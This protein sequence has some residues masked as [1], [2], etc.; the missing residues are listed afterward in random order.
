[1]ELEHVLQGGIIH[2]SR[3]I[4]SILEEGHLYVEQARKSQR[5]PLISVLMHGPPGSGKTALAA[6]IAKNSEFPFAKLISPENMIQ[7]SERSKVNYLSK[8]FEDAYKSP[9]SVVIVDN[10]ER[11]L[12]FAPIG[13]QFSNA[14]L[15]TLLILFCRKP[16]NGRRLLIIATTTQKSV[17]EQ[18][19]LGNSFVADIGV[20]NV[21][22]YSELAHILHALQV[23]ESPEKQRKTLEELQNMSGTTYLNVGIKK[24]LMLVETARQ[25]EDTEGSFLLGMSRAAG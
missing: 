4:D 16:P 14:V 7:F 1:M 18:M 19:G 20:P 10:I 21:S 15:Q 24:I 22:K 6:S 12:E 13:P 3:N 23:F 17:V 5:T 2:Y 9:F 25:D 8:V 11:I